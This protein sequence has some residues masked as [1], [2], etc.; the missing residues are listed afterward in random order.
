MIFLHHRSITNP[1]FSHFD[2]YLVSGESYL[3]LFP[4]AGCIAF[5]EKDS[6][7]GGGREGEKGK[8]QGE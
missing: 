4:L 5:G 1:Q 7:K 8:K 6:R 3:V 2:S